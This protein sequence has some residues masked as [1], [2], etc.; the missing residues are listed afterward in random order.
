M[1]IKLDAEAAASIA[2]AAIFDSLSEEAR[3]SVIKQAIEHLLTPVKNDRFSVGPGQTPLQTAFNQALSTAAYKAVADKVAN[4]PQVTAK[5]DE[6]LGPLLNK[7]LEA[8][9]ENYD[10]SL[11]D[12][13]GSALGQWLA[14]KARSQR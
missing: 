6:L 7:A 11:S 2:S 3:D 12:K 8:E 1:E 13:L 9:A 5:I 14:E 4:D 10:N